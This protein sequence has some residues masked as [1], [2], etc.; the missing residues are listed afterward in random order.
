MLAGIGVEMR[1]A[2]PTEAE[3]G[4]ALFPRKRKRNNGMS[5]AQRNTPSA[6]RTPNWAKPVEPLKQSARKPIPVVIATQRIPG[7]QCLMDSTIALSRLKP[8]LRD[9]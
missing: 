8:M 7:V 5:T 1:R 2:G 3:V 6:T 9:W 4:P